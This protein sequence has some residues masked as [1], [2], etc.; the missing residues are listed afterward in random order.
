MSEKITQVF[1]L[2]EATI[3]S[4]NLLIIKAEALHEQ[5]EIRELDEIQ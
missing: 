1:I 2:N 4:E 5:R 3:E